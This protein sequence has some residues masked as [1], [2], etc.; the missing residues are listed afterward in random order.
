MKKIFGIAALI[1]LL[2]ACKYEEGPFISFTSV[3][4]RIR[5]A[6]S[7]STV[8]KNG[9]ITDTESPSIVESKRAKYE[10]FKRNILV[11]SYINNDVLYESS[12]SWEFGNKKKTIN[13]VFMNQYYNLSREYEI[14]KFKSNE[15]KV[16]FTDDNGMKW[17]LV[18]GLEY[19][20]VPYDM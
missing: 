12:G 19:S 16:R 10:F 13:A 8:Y 9:E 7:V 14:V 2:S 3:E 5:G 15:L 4:K 11:I 6:W 1:I 18:L 20:F 17:S